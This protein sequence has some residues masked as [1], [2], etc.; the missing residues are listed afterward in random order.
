MKSFIGKGLH[1]S[2]TQSYY[3][4][5]NRV[6]VKF[7][8]RDI[9]HLH[10]ELFDKE[11]M[12]ATK[13]MTAEESWQYILKTHYKDTPQPKKQK[14]QSEPV[15][16]R[17]NLRARTLPGI[18][19]E[20]EANESKRIHKRVDQK[21]EHVI[22]SWN[23]LDK[24]KLT[25]EIVSDIV[26]KYIL[27][28]GQNSV[29]TGTVH[30]ELDHLHVHL[31]VGA[32]L[33]GLSSRISKQRFQEIKMELQAYQQEKYPELFNSLPKHQA[34]DRIKEEKGFYK[35]LKNERTPVKNDLLKIIETI[36]TTSTKNMATLLAQHGYVPYERGG[37]VTGLIH[38]ETGL[39]FRFSRLPL[40]LA[41]LKEHTVTKEEQDLHH[42]KELRDS[43]QKP[44]NPPEPDTSQD[45][46]IEHLAKLRKSVSKDMDDYEIE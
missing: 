29:V 7:T 25:N 8:E 39:K 19:K 26:Q 17:H 45:S 5:L 12:R 11:L 16:F 6:G 34:I 13:G 42:L 41:P 18:I 38:S 2:I 27:I 33:N 23:D 10:S 43:P 14:E 4:A 15:M 37:K 32:Q 1:D 31:A 22:L 20:F 28:R 35:I 40:E 30:T 24:T 3:D 46:E 21:V 9:Q 36:K 44:E